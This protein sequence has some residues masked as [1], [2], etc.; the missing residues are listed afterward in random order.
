[1]F[2]SKSY[3]FNKIPDLSGKLAV[4]TGSNTGIGKVCALEMARKNCH[5]VIASRT[6]SKGLA[7]VDEIKQVTGNDKVEFMQLNL[8]SLQ[9]VKR[10]AEAFKAK[11]DRLDILMNNAGVM[12]CPFGLSEDGL[13]TQ[14]GTN[15]IAHYYLTILLLPVIEKTP[16]ARIVNV[17]SAGHAFSMLSGIDYDTINEEKGYSKVFQYG[18]SKAANILF[19]RELSRRLEEK[20]VDVYVNCNHPGVVRSELTRHIINQKSILE[21]IYD[22]AMTIT[23][24]DGALAQLYLATSPEVESKKIKGQYYVPY[25]KPGWTVP[26]VKSEKNAK[27]LWD[28]S[29]KILK[30][31]VPGYDGAPL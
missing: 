27:D 23:T 12:M 10:F 20:G 4:I 7:A 26:F 11:H 30:E 25:G 2:W 22:A 8:L 17:S 9:S 21:S 16:K 3:S 13:E 29:E 28:Y 18:K 24:E 1:M 31:K 15:H 19:T 14:F 5:V 6:E